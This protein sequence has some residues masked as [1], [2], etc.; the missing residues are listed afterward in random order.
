MPK[1]PRTLSKLLNPLKVLLLKLAKGNKNKEYTGVE[2]RN[3]DQSISQTNDLCIGEQ[4]STERHSC[5]CHVEE[6]LNLAKKKNKNKKSV[7][8]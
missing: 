1:T 4:P 8:D 5:S 2:P 7:V 3:K 6:F